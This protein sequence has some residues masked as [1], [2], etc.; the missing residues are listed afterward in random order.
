MKEELLQNVGGVYNEEDGDEKEV[1][2]GDDQDT[3]EHYADQTM[4]CGQF[5]TVGGDG[6]PS[7]TTLGII[8]LRIP[9][10]YTGHGQ[11]YEPFYWSDRAGGAIM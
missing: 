4:F 6:N 1:E 7:N 3:R 10:I 9:S 8:Y 2:C 11:E 5:Y